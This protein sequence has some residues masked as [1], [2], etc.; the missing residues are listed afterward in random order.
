M[1]PFRHID[2]LAICVLLAGIAFISQVRQSPAFVYG[3]A[4]VAAFTT[5]HL[6]PIFSPPVAYKLCLSRD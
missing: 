6:A 5:E 2:V 1:K 3:S 4:R